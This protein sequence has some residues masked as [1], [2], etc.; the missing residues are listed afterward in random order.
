LL[1]VAAIIAIL[2]NEK[3][4]KTVPQ[5]WASQKAMLN[6]IIVHQNSKPYRHESGL[7]NWWGKFR[8][9]NLRTATVAVVN[10]SVATVYTPNFKAEPFILNTIYS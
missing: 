3:E 9:G 10:G 4:S 8:L 2:Q 1:P 7:I 5:Q 6:Q